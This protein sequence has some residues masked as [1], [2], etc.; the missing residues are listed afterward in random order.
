MPLGRVGP[1]G[2]LPSPSWT[3]LTTYIQSSWDYYVG[4]AVNILCKTLR[5][6]GPMWVEKK[7]PNL[8]EGHCAEQILW[9][10]LKRAI[11]QECS[12]LVHNLWH[13]KILR[14]RAEI[15]GHRWSPAK[16]TYLWRHCCQSLWYF[17]N[18]ASTDHNRGQWIVKDQIFVLR[19]ASKYYLS[20]SVEDVL[21]GEDTDIALLY[22][23][24]TE[25]CLLPG[26]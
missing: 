10:A 7:W 9:V 17:R 6:K 15:R 3:S 24:S 11:L 22:S 23:S 1:W 16:T 12:A 8:L 4:G 5:F 20:F 25:L 21:E 14:I 18:W 19:L 26:I 13:L 2:T